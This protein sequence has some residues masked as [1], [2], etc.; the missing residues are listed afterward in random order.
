M[1]KYSFTDRNGKTWERVTK[2]QA[3]AAYNNGLTVVFCPVNMR[4][5]GPWGNGVT[6]NISNDTDIDITDRFTRENS[7]ERVLNSFEYYN[8]NDNET[9]LYTAFYLPVVTVDKFTGK[10]PTKETRETVRAYDYTVL[11]G[12]KNV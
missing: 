7:F 11:E 8:C 12:V 6:V 9:G 3:R 2:K 5:W 10:A 4:P 1:R